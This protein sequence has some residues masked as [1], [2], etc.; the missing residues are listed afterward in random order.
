ML[1][2]AR[3]TLAVVDRC[4]FLRWWRRRGVSVIV[5][6]V[7]ASVYR[8]F[9]FQGVRGQCTVTSM[10]ERGDRSVGGCEER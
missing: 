5:T 4:G 10:N 1:R 6:N 3:A 9:D 8:T 2:L 7:R